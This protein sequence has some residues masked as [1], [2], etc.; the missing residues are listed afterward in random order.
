MILA[1]D[2]DGVI[3]DS[4]REHAVSS[5]LASVLVSPPEGVATGTIPE[6]YYSYF[7]HERPELEVGYQGVQIALRFR[8]ANST[9]DYSVE[10]LSNALSKIRD[11]RFGQ[12]PEDWCEE[13][14]FYPGMAK[15]LRLWL[16]RSDK[17]VYIVTKKLRRY[18]EALLDHNNVEFPLDQLHGLEDG[19]KENCLRRLQMKYPKESI[20]FVEDRL[21]TLERISSISEFQPLNLVFA[22][23]GYSSVDH[24]ERARTR[25]DLLYFGI[26]EFLN[27]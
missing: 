15:A 26:Q 1:L 24:K 4:V 11:D 12:A 3:C 2:F 7:Q 19:P 20:Y 16:S 8:N 10:H 14:P 27:L 18:T 17:H 5:W 13:S 23:W 6:Q 21:A 9:E 22:S 25:S